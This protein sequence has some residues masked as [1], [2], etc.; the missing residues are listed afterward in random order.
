MSKETTAVGVHQ[1]GGASPA[2]ILRHRFNKPYQCY[3]R[4]FRR[5]SNDVVVCWACF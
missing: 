4:I 2:R 5:G 3:K 1:K